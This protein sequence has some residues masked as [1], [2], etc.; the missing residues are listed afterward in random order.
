MAYDMVQEGLQWLLEVAFSEEQAVPANFYLGLSQSD[1]ATLTETA[2][3]ASINEVTGTGYARQT[4]ASDNVDFTSA[5]AGTNDRKQTTKT[6]TF[7]ASASDWDDA[8][9]AF[10]ATSS[11]GSGK[12]VAIVDLSETRSLVNGDSLEV[13]MVI[14]ING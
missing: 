11:D 14:Q 6:V 7:T 13:S 3:L 12:L 8:E 10:L 4:V 1:V 2:T 9:S 5:V